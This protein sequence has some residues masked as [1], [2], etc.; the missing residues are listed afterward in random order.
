MRWRS[1]L[2][3]IGDAVFA[4]SRSLPPGFG[5]LGIAV[6][7]EAGAV[8]S[9]AYAL[10]HTSRVAT[11]CSS[12]VDLINCTRAAHDTWLIVLAACLAIAGAYLA[13]RS[14]RPRPF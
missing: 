4:T 12:G 6:V 11:R 7:F 9:L 5:T 2:R 13:P 10:T 1:D 8:T 14:R 3:R